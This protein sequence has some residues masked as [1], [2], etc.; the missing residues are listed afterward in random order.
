MIRGLK[1]KRAISERQLLPFRAVLPED[2]DRVGGKGRQ[3]ETVIKSLA[4]EHLTL[5]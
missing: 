5:L 2:R 3:K 4:T 1:M